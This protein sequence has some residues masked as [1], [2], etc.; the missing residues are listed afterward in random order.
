MIAE[1]IPKVA[2]QQMLDKGDTG[3]QKY[4]PRPSSAGP[5]RCI[6]QMVYH[7]MGLPP[8]PLPGRS[9]L[10][11][12]DSTWHEELTKQ[13]VEMSAFKL[14]SDQMAITIPN[15][16]PWRVPGTIRNC[17][18]CKVQ[19]EAGD[20]HGHIDFIVTDLAQKDWLIEHKAINHFT[21]N[22]IW[23]KQAWPLDYLAQMAVYFRGLAL[24]HSD[25]RQGLLLIKN[26]NT[27]QYIEFEVHYDVTNDIFKITRGMRSDGDFY[28]VD[29]AYPNIFKEAID[30][31]RM[32]EDVHI[33]S[34][35]LPERPY[36]F[37]DRD[38]FPC[39]YCAWNETC[40]MGYETELMQR[41]TMT[42]LPE[43]F[44][45]CIEYLKIVEQEGILKKK[46]ETVKEM[47]RMQ[48]DAKATRE[49]HTMGHIIEI[50]MTHKEPYTVKGGDSERMSIKAK[51]YGRKDDTRDRR[52]KR[53]SS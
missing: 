16:M 42:Q 28:D 33:K 19:Y 51:T 41:S 44:E 3:F 4:S 48:M 43:A 9:L 39:G 30:K 22:R 6:R 50:K 49:A 38:G 45:N 34:K 32:V 23:D 14:H 29:F 52:S 27:A 15:C 40:W 10:V 5:E 20:I 26:K 31:F 18:I 46:K 53:R 12:D 8:K 11:F 36:Q 2:Q 17:R 1:I 24:V 37:E 35:T 25:L 47:I 21:F 13:W 7:A